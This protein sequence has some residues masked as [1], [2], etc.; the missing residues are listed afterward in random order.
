MPSESQ[1]L[2]FLV[3]CQGV[4]IR[5]KRNRSQDKLFERVLR[6]DAFVYVGALI[7]RGKNVNIRLVKLAPA[8]LQ[9]CFSLVEQMQNNTV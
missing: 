4:P 5:L 2:H 7:T 8:L 6:S 3:K 1:V 9:R